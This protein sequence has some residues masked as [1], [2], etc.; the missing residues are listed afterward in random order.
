MLGVS[1]E[2]KQDAGYKSCYL[3]ISNGQLVRSY[4]GEKSYYDEVAGRLCS[5]RAEERDFHRGALEKFWYIDLA[6]DEE[7]MMYH[8]STPYSSGVFLNII[9]S[10]ASAEHLSSQTTIRLHTYSKNGYT[11]A[12]VF[13]DGVKLDWVV[14]ELPP[15]KTIQLGSQS[16]KDDSERMEMLLGYV[17]QI[18]A[19]IKPS[20]SFSKSGG[21]IYPK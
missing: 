7:Q 12:Q 14:K 2:N 21:V 13:A 4:K 10:L 15:V 19:K 3:S 9:L 6:D 18:E 1:N 20:E 5:I 11:K 17:R 8:I 16:V